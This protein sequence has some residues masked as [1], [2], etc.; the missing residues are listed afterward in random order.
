[1]EQAGLSLTWSQTNPEDR[2][3]HDEIQTFIFSKSKLWSF[4][5]PKIEQEYIDAPCSNQEN[6]PV[7]D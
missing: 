6:S 3:S 1:M 2:F 4:E 7:P 5:K